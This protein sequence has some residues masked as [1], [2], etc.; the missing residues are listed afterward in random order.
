[1]KGVKVEKFR[2]WGRTALPSYH[3]GQNSNLLQGVYGSEGREKG[4]VGGVHVLEGTSPAFGAH[5]PVKEAAV[6]SLSASPDWAWLVWGSL[7]GE[8]ALARE[9]FLE[10]EARW[11]WGSARGKRD[12]VP[13]F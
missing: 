2:G 10:E 1:M 5:S 7:R 4:G 9:G 8:P 12:V 3:R 13:V 11:A 6:S